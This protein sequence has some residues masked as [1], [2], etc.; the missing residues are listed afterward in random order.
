M[1]RAGSHLGEDVSCIGGGRGQGGEEGGLARRLNG[2]GHPQLR[3]FQVGG[4]AVGVDE[5]KDVV[6]ACGRE[7]RASRAQG[8]SAVSTVRP[9]LGQEP[10]PHPPCSLLLTPVP[11]STRPFPPNLSPLPTFPTILNLH[12]E[13]LPIPSSPWGLHLSYAKDPPPL[14]FYPPTTPIPRLRGLEGDFLEPPWKPGFASWKKALLGTE[15][16][17]SQGPLPWQQRQLTNA[18]Y[19]EGGHPVEDAQ[20]LDTKDHM[21]QEE[22][23]QA[24]EADAGNSE[25]GQE[26]WAGQ[27]PQGTDGVGGPRGTHLFSVPGPCWVLPPTPPTPGSTSTTPSEPSTVFCTQRRGWAG[28]LRG[29]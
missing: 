23:H 9:S 24:A 16:P 7:P 27:E 8:H 6:H 10:K 19:H 11:T 14:I 15:F 28:G 5:Y 25:E 21:V 22:C 13:E 26:H 29:K 2:M 12:P 20:V 3:V 4:L 18:H 17:S 1:G